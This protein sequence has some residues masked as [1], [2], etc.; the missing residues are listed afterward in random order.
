[1][2]ATQKGRSNP[3]RISCNRSE[4]F[5]EH[6]VWRGH[7][8]PRSDHV[9]FVNRLRTSSAEIPA[10]RIALFRLF[11]PEAMVTEERGTFKRFAKNSIQAWLA[12]PSTG[13][14]VRD[15][16]SASPTSPVIAF[17]LARGW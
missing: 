2:F 13:G 11:K 3:V 5:N 10:T 7:S 9:Q 15:S 8:C 16:L 6:P 12:F 4:K 1:M 14:A 17:F